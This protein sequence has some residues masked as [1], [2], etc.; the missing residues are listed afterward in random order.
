MGLSLL[1]DPIRRAS[2][3][4]RGYSPV[5]LRRDLLAG[6]SV[7]VIAVPQSIAYALIAGVPAEYGLYT[8]IFQC[9]IGSMLNS[10]PL[11]SVGPINT[12]SLVVASI[13][14]RAVSPADPSAY[15]AIVV[16]LALVKG[17]LQMAMALLRLGALVKYVSRSVL[18]GFTAGAGVLIAAGQVGAFVGVTTSKPEGAWPGIVGIVQGLAPALGEANA[19]SLAL[20]A[21]ALLV[22]GGM[23]AVRL[24]AL[25][26][27]TGVAVAA[28]VVALAGLTPQQVNLMPPLPQALPSPAL[29]RLDAAQAELLVIG[30]L[31]LSLLGLMEAY[32][33]GRTLAAKTNTR[34]DA[35]QELF[36]QGLTN[37][38]GSFL[39]C[40]PGSGSFSRSALNHRAGAAT[41]LAGLFN[42]L[43]VLTIFLALAPLARFVPMSSIAAVLFIVAFGLIDWRGFLRVLRTSPGEAGVCAATFLAT[44]TL[45]L[46]YAVL[47]GVILNLALYL[48]TASRL[49]LAEMIATDG[50]PFREQPLRESS[51]RQRLIFLQAEGELFFAVAD[52][53]EDRLGAL[54]KG[55]VRVV[56][57]RLRRTHS[58]DATVLDVL[59][60]FARDIRGRGGALILCG[61]RPEVLRQFDRY[62]LT[63]VVGRDN[64][65]EVAD[66]VFTSAK[67][68]IQRAREI[69][70]Y[71]IDATGIDTSEEAEFTYVI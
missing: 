19:W 69:V 48:H 32:S 43:F 68:A 15:L 36:S 26:P 61:V 3:T 27:L 64:I 45:P 54:L 7:A 8:L 25:G 23:N 60:R 34:V 28:L 65:F 13:A 47:L 11:L 49:H 53:L 71:S 9:L 22:I 56:I 17:L 5:S 44:L 38:L 41:S 50:G 63:R 16:G 70:G 33:I 29:P 24:G 2:E 66:G 58:I 12:Q 39:S 62:G 51:G 30:G 18:L 37:A 55:D 1:R 42:A 6:L 20:G 21:G 59:E 10:Q 46:A 35:N 14:T 67:Q 4:L 40:I 57:L 52:E 31:A